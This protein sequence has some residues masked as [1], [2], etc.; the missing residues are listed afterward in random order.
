MGTPTSLDLGLETG[1]A[2]ADKTE[3]LQAFARIIKSKLIMVTGDTSIITPSGNYTVLDDTTKLATNGWLPLE[4]LI[5]DGMR[6]T[7]ED[8][9][10]E[11]AYRWNTKYLE[12]GLSV[13]DFDTVT[14]ALINTKALAN[15]CI[16]SAR[17]MDS[18]LSGLTTRE[19][20]TSESELQAQ[21]MHEELNVQR[22]TK[23]L[24]YQL[25]NALGICTASDDSVTMGGCGGVW[26]VASAGGVVPNEPGGFT[27]DPPLDFRKITGLKEESDSDE[28]PPLAL[29]K[30]EFMNNLKAGL[31][32][33]DLQLG[34]HPLATDPWAGILNANEWFTMLGDLLISTR[35]LKHNNI[36]STPTGLA[37]L[38]SGLT[39]M[40]INKLTSLKVNINTFMTS[41]GLSA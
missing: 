13:S 22:R 6:K 30:H 20:P 17:R 34:L 14:D 11:T 28:L 4:I 40:Y 15:V 26:E 38:L 27:T 41:A 18:A 32:K 37:D 23:E 3:D 8:L 19:P 9:N 31:S 1:N 7:M 5:V 2:A 12:D 24:V 16:A 21:K 29:S 35:F 36:Y 33:S 39:I 10:D 25:N